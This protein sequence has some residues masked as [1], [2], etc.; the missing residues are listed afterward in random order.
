MSVK[1]ITSNATKLFEDRIAVLR[2]LN[3]QSIDPSV[4]NSA[5]QE[6]KNIEAIFVSARWQSRHTNPVQLIF[7][8][9]F[10]HQVIKTRREGI[11]ILY[12]DCV[13]LVS[14][15]YTPDDAAL[16]VNRK[17]DQQLSELTFIK[18]QTTDASDCTRKPIPESVR[19]EVWRRD[20]GKCVQCGSNRN[21]EYDHLIPFSRGGSNTARNLRLLCEACNRTK[22]NQL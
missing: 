10:V 17:V 1:L 8:G 13:Y 2:T 5:F 3:Y 22:S 6:M 12:K 9:P 7:H 21:L 20:Q 11:L 19:H 15:P 14:G 4:R 16:L 18:N